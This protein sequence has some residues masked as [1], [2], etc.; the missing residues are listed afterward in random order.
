VPAPDHHTHQLITFHKKQGMCNGDKKCKACSIASI[1]KMAKTRKSSKN[2][3]LMDTAAVTGGLF[4]GAVAVPKVVDMIDKTGT[5][6]PNYI[7]GGTAALAVF[8]AMK[9][10]GTTQ[11]VLIGVGAGAA[12]KLLASVTGMGYVDSPSYD[13]NRVMGAVSTGGG[14]FPGT[15]G[16]NPGAI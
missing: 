9:T 10:K 6:D 2:T 8:G 15:T 16:A 13:V 11:K 14:N 12:V 7:N 5:I 4:L 1:G 3:V